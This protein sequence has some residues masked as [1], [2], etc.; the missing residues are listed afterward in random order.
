M[1]AL[2][3]SRVAV[4]SFITRQAPAMVP[5]TA[6]FPSNFVGLLPLPPS[7]TSNVPSR[8]FSTSPLAAYSTGP[9]KASPASSAWTSGTASPKIKPIVPPTIASAAAATTSSSST[10]KPGSSTSAQGSSPNASN[11]N[12]DGSLPDLSW[13]QYFA[14]RASRLT[15]ERLTGI[16]GGA[17]G[18][19]AGSYYFGFVVDVKPEPFFGFLDPAI[20]YGMG[21]FAVAGVAAALGT[22]GGGAIWRMRQGSAILK[23]IDELKSIL[24]D[25]LQKER[26]FFLRIQSVRPAE[27]TL[28]L[29]NPLPDYYGEGVKSV[30]DYRSWLRKQRDGMIRNILMAIIATSLLSWTPPSYAAPAPSGSLCA[31]VA[32]GEAAR[33]LI[34]VSKPPLSDV[35]AAKQEDMMLSHFKWLQDIAGG[36]KAVKVVSQ[37]S[38]GNFD[39]YA[40]EFPGG[41]M[42]CHR[43]LAGVAQQ[44]AGLASGGGIVIDEAEEDEGF[45]LMEVGQVRGR[46]RVKEVVGL[47]GGAPWGLDR[48]DQPS[49]PLDGKFHYP[50][51]AGEG[52]DIYIIDTGISIDHKD[53]GGRA[54][55][56]ITTRSGSPDYDDNG[57]GSHVAGI[58][59]G[60]VFGVAK[61]ANLIAVKALDAGG[62]G[63]YSELIDGIQWVANQTRYSK[64]PTIAN[65]SIQGQKSAVLNKAIS[66]LI[67]MGIHVVSAAGNM[68]KDACQFSPAYVLSM[69]V[70]IEIT[71]T[72]DDFRLGPGKDIP[73]VFAESRDRFV[74]LSGTS[75]AAPHASG[76]IAVLLSMGYGMSP[77]EMKQYLIQTG[78]EG[79]ATDLRG[80]PITYAKMLN[81]LP[82]S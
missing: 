6:R 38:I 67:D 80:Q 44:E 28:S 35:S 29:Q 82:E 56:G 69:L 75:M 33:Y 9:K 3:R 8:L 16:L 37:W 73:S 60:N 65:L 74:N 26:Q 40:L 27:V 52:V 57:H 62:H 34:S 70:L 10:L 63:P 4:S 76:T 61:R 31:R 51:E 68:K 53:F 36:P 49:L 12:A 30:A 2:A 18:F 24:A 72:E 64:R 46:G 15:H 22:V 48:I 20:V 19:F 43:F 41:F 78:V 7:I 45:G 59:A 58:A 17:V 77:M 23:A 79:V 81:F 71:E 14:L 13:K 66:G 39:G 42:A 54:R 50:K 55:W 1:T 21:I 32:A 11:A 25:N 5:A 47:E